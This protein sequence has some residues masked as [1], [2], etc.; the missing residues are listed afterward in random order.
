MGCFPPG[1]QETYGYLSPSPSAPGSSVSFTQGENRTEW[2]RRKEGYHLGLSF[3]KLLP[4]REKRARPS[5]LPLGES[6]GGGT[7]LER[8]WLCKLSRLT[9]AEKACQSPVPSP[10]THVEP[11]KLKWPQFQGPSWWTEDKGPDR[12]TDTPQHNYTDKRH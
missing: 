6:W 5:T 2:N 1:V 10:S 3:Q 8:P 4:G 7:I 12:K 11:P 9:K